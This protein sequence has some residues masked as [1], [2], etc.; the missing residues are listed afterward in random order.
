MKETDHIY[1]PITIP[2]NLAWPLNDIQDKDTII[3]QPHGFL[4]GTWQ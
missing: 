1:S 2:E 4:V 3:R